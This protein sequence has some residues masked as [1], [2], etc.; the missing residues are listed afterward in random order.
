[1]EI[2]NNSFYCPGIV[3]IK[4]IDVRIVKVVLNPSNTVAILSPKI[5]HSIKFGINKINKL[6][7]ENFYPSLLTWE[8]DLSILV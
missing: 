8:M 6:N 1:M 2:Y 4:N 3:C 5:K 7:S